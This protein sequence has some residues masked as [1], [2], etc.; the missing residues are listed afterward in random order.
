MPPDNPPSAPG[1]LKINGGDSLFADPLVSSA[2]APTATWTPGTDPDLSDTVTHE[3][4]F[5]SRSD[6]S[7]NPDTGTASIARD[8]TGISGG[9]L[10]VSPVLAPGQYYW[11][12]R[13][14]D[15][16]LY[17]GWSPVGT[18][19]VNAPPGPPTGL[20]VADAS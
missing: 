18:F 17:S 12:V 8:V 4:Q 11:R 5:S 9:S 19:R 6:F 2:S 13:A 1:L 7:Q 14:F 15:G 3:V 20:L 16:Q 10:L